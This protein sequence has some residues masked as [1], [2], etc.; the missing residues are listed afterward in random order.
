[1]TSATPAAVK[2][3][4][5]KLAF[6]HGM[7]AHTVNLS[8]LPVERRRFLA[9][10]GQRLTPHHLEPRRGSPRYRPGPGPR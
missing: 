10:V 3:E 6:L 4:L 8:V 9:G 7:D 5:D 2:G 1:V